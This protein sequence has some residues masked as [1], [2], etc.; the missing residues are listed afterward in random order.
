M[1]LGMLFTRGL[2]D[3]MNGRFDRVREMGR[4]RLEE[5]GREAYHSEQEE[6][7]CSAASP[8]IRGVV[9]SKQ[10]KSVLSY[11]VSIA[12]PFV[13]LRFCYRRL[14]RRGEG[15]SSRPMRPLS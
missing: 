15:Y 6:V 11:D 4:K 13:V 12:Y 10:P 14:R 1:A 5:T 8:H 7:L 3:R 9:R 2:Y